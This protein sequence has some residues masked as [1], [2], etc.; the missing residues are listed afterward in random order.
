MSKRIT[1][2]EQKTYDFIKEQNGIQVSSLPKM[3]WGAIPNLKH[4]GL[5]ETY[6]KITNPWATKKHTFVKIS[7]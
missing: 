7:E 3:M 6:K 4:V 5:V 2:F 1:E